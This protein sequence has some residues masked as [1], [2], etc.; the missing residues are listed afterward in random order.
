MSDKRVNNDLR[1]QTERLCSGLLPSVADAIREL[2]RTAYWAGVS[3]TNR[4]H[5]PVQHCDN[6]SIFEDRPSCLADSGREEF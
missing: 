1:D 6:T 4:L 5:K 2:V 3:D